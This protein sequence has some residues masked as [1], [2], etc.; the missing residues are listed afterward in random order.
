[1]RGPAAM[2]RRLAS[3]P[4]FELRATLARI[5]PLGD[6]VKNSPPDFLFA[7]G[8]PNR[9]NTAGIECVLTPTSRPAVF[10]RFNDS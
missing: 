5:V 4:I 1:M 8:K 2:K 7:S 9:F 6:L 10:L 3:V